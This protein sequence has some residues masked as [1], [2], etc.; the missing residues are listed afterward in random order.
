[1]QG[2]ISGV[3]ATGDDLSTKTMDDVA[4]LLGAATGEPAQA[5]DGIERLKAMGVTIE[6]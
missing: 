5:N 4:K 6:D 3:L 2:E 1:M